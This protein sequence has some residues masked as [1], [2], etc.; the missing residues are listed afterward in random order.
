M[1]G[2]ALPVPLKLF[3][4]YELMQQARGVKAAAPTDLFYPDLSPRA[5]QDRQREVGHAAET[6]VATWSSSGDCSSA[7]CSP[8]CAATRTARAVMRDAVQGI[9]DVQTHAA[10][11]SFWWAVG[12]LLEGIVEKGVESGFGVK[13]LCGRVDLQIRRFVE[14]SAKVADRMRREVLYFVAISAP[15]GPQVQAV[16]R[17]YRLQGLIPTAEVLSADVVRVQPRLREARDQLAT[18]KDLWLKLTGGRAENL[19]KLKQTLFDTARQVRRH[20]RA[21]AVET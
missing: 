18:A 12:A 1:V 17:A 20:R 15:V 2:G 11:R 10:Q 19:P 14:G 3:P 8:G 7:A 9:E 16:Q 6:A 13:Q 21:V 5:P 4:E